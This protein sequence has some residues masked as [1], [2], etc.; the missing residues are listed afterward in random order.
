MKYYS[1]VTKAFYETEDKCKAAEKA[2]I[3]QER[4]LK[5]EREEAAAKK[6][7]MET[8]KEA[9]RKVVLEAFENAQTKLKEY[10]DKYG[11]LTFSSSIFPKFPW[12]FLDWP[13]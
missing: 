13:L 1:E 2:A 6:K 5:K 9:A 12:A 3:E 7:A 10:N 11:A 8:E 4:K